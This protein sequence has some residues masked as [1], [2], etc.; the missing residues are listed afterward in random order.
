[1][2]DAEEDAGAQ[3]VAGAGDNPEHDPK[4]PKDVEQEIQML[5]AKAKNRLEGVT[6]VMEDNGSRI[7]TL[8]KGFKELKRQQDHV[9]RE[10]NQTIGNL[11]NGLKSN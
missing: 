1:M 3:E 2:G 6:S 5:I 11:Q 8:Q 9:T 7:K 10:Q 4:E